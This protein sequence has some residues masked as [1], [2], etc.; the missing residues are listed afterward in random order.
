MKVCTKC[1]AQ[2]VP[3]GT[4]WCKDCTKIYRKKYRE[5][6]KERIA[7]LNHDWRQNN[8][9]HYKEHQYD[10]YATVK[11]RI[12]NLLKGARK[13]AKAKSMQYDLDIIWLTN[14]FKEQ[15]NKCL[16]TGLDF[17]IPTNRNGSKAHPLAPSLDRINSGEGYTKINTRLVCVAINYG[18]N[19]FGE[20][21]FKQICQA[22]LSNQTSPNI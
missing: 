3:Q 14:L 15:N 4:S 21:I 5:S 2:V 10:Y 6:N 9:E 13:R 19:E 12:Q 8:K 20:D 17:N 11:G 16:L 1:N 7:K 22:Y 18:M